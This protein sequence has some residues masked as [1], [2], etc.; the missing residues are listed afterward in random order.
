MKKFSIKSFR[1]AFN[2][3]LI[4]FTEPNFKFHIV[5]SILV[6]VGGLILHVSTIEWCLLVGSIGFVLTIEILNTAIEHIMNFVHP[7]FEERVGEIKDVAAAGVLISSITAF[8]V[9]SIIFIPKL[10]ELFS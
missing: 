10:L 1:P 6:I 9:G 3:I 4:T 2:G 5:A 7:G 8:I